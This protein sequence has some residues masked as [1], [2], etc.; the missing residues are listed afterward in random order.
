ML[1]H[2]VRIAHRMVEAPLGGTVVGLGAAVE[3]SGSG[4]QPTWKAPG[5]LPSSF[6]HIQSWVTKFT[7][8]ISPSGHCLCSKVPLAKQYLHRING[9]ECKGKK[10]LWG[11]FLLQW[12]AKHMPT[13][14]RIVIKIM[15]F[16]WT[17]CSR[18]LFSVDHHTRSL[19]WDNCQGHHR[20]ILQV[21]VT[22]AID[23]YCHREHSPVLNLPGQMV[24]TVSLIHCQDPPLRGSAS[25]KQPS[26]HSIRHPSTSSPQESSHKKPY[27]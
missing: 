15:I 25:R 21:N 2:R 11:F 26:A 13:N 8:T 12:T 5:H 16:T 18:G 23:Q 1:I 24:C 22:I 19:R 27:D 3:Q 6:A 4:S 10:A 14:M 17:L 9:K 20:R 7:K